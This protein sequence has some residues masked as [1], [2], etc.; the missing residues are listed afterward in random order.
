MKWMEKMIN[1]TLRFVWEYLEPFNCVQAMITFVYKQI[2]SN[3]F[4]TKITKKF[5][6][7]KLYV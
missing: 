3:E 1:T 6:S 4:K 5:L 7:Y 2:N